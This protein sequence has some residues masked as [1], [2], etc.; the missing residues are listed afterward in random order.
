MISGKSKIRKDFAELLLAK[1]GRTQGRREVRSVERHAAHNT[2]QSISRSR[3]G[4]PSAITRIEKFLRPSAAEA[5]VDIVMNIGAWRGK[6]HEFA[7]LLFL[8]APWRKKDSAK[9]IP[10]GEPLGECGIFRN[11]VTKSGLPL[12]IELQNFHTMEGRR[13]RV[14]SSPVSAVSLRELQKWLTSKTPKS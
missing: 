6:D 8:R 1:L 2:V 10:G 5:S 11:T 14:F 12:Y 13:D 4:M 7:K 9:E 3:T